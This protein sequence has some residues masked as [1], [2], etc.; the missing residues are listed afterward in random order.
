M[1][2]LLPP[3]MSE[4][5]R[6]GSRRCRCP[7]P[8]RRDRPTRRGSEASPTLR[9]RRQGR[10]RPIRGRASKAAAVRRAPT[11]ETAAAGAPTPRV[12]RPAGTPATRAVSPL[13]PPGA[14]KRDTARAMSQE[15]VE[16]LREAYELLNTRFAA[17]KG[18]DLDDLLAFFD[19][20]VVIEMVDTPDPE[21][22]HGHDGV[23]SWFNDAFG[24][25]AAVHVEAEDIKESGQWTSPC[26]IHLCAERRVVSSWSFRQPPSISFA[27]AG[28]CSTACIW[29]ATRASKPSPSRSRRCRRRTWRSCAGPLTL[30]TSEA[31]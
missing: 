24:P 6:A 21:T 30:S 13:R 14:R 1:E 9:S 19:P 23:R 5:H 25:W 7:R 26:F 31:T 8:G 27:A 2:I 12:G 16:R 10:T 15:N 29:I 3:E 17:L 20:E 28:S 11:R 22:Y 4:R 18:G